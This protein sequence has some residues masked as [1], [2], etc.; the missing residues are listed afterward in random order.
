MQVQSFSHT[1]SIRDDNQ[2][3]LFV[4]PD[5]RLAIIADG[6]GLA[7]KRLA[8]YTA[9][10]VFQRLREIAPV[11]GGDENLFRLREAFELASQNATPELTN[12]RCDVAAAWISRGTV[13]VFATGACRL[14]SALPEQNWLEQREFAV[15]AATGTALML[16][17]EGAAAALSSQQL[18]PALNGMLA[19]TNV[20]GFAT[21][22]QQT[23]SVYDGDDCSA[24]LLRL[25]ET[26]LTA[27]IPHE[28]E[29][30]EHYNRAYSCKL[31]LP[32]SIAAGAGLA[33]LAAARKLKPL[34]DR[35]KS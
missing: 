29:L 18:Q 7:G 19:A 17:S 2:D 13:A 5:L 20:N 1:G 33:T 21:F 15:P 34:L 11:T 30:F 10:A 27:G 14:L 9:A 35:I 31:W 16:V 25:D 12:S 8:E 26:D 4:D 28:I 6:H 3:H 24:I 23:T 22:E 32:L